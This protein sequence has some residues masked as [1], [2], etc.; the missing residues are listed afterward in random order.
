MRRRACGRPG[1][2]R[3]RDDRPTKRSRVAC[4][5]RVKESVMSSGDTREAAASDKRA[6]RLKKSLEDFDRTAGLLRGELVDR[7]G[8]P[9]ADALVRP[10]PT[11]SY[12]TRA[13]A[14]ARSF[15]ACAGSR[16]ALRR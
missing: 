9:D 16:A 6:R 1:R 3:C 4:C 12:E 11:P 2:G 5:S 13:L 10:M 15:P 7:Y 14:T 8:E